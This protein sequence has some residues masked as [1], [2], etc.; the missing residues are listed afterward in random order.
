[1]KGQ[2]SSY[3]LARSGS[4]RRT[5]Q[6]A[7]KGARGL[8]RAKLVTSVGSL[9]DLVTR[10]CDSRCHDDLCLL[11]LSVTVCPRV[12]HS[13]YANLCLVICPFVCLCFA[14]GLCAFLSIIDI[15]VNMV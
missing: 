13:V 11:L 6:R 9:R 12:C 4:G 10:L 8:I 5:G 7:G 1:M 14:A 15:G 2:R 3:R